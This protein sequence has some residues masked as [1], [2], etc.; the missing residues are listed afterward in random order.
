MLNQPTINEIIWGFFSV[1]S[2][3]KKIGGR[4]AK[5]WGVLA[6]AFSRDARMGKTST[7]TLQYAGYSQCECLVLHQFTER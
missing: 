4:F 1:F 3:G 7:E 5:S 6:K 2:M